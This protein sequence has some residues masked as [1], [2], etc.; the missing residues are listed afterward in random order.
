[1]QFLKKTKRE[2]VCNVFLKMFP[3]ICE[4]FLKIEKNV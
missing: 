2:Y 4:V 1:M 3:K